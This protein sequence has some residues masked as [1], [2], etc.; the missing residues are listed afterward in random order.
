[1]LTSTFHNLPLWVIIVNYFFKNYILL[2]K[3]RKGS[4]CVSK[5]LLFFLCNTDKIN[6]CEARQARSDWILEVKIK[7]EALA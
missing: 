6:E 5:Y 7:K 4:T 3:K 1:V 2:H